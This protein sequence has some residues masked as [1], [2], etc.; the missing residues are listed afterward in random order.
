M[1]PII[2]GRILPLALFAAGVVLTLIATISTPAAGAEIDGFDAS[3]SR[4]ATDR[5]HDLSLAESDGYALLVD[6]AGISCID[7]PVEG[8]M[9]VHYTNGDLVASGTVDPLKPQVLV[10]E[11]IAEGELSLAA[12]EYV[13][14]QEDWDATHATPPVLFDHEFMLT[15]EGNRYGLPPFYSLHAW[16]WKDNSSG[17]FANWNPEVSCE[18]S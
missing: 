13:V 9:G 4:G 17:A 7:D 2:F 11:P 12:V 3:A 5:Y 8:A 18:A 6:T 15:P 14:L 1:I 16:I 10:Y